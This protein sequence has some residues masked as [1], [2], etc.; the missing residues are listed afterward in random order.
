[1]FF[2]QSSLKFFGPIASLIAILFVVG[3][4]S[5]ATAQSNE[6]GS[7]KVNW[8]IYMQHASTA[9]AIAMAL[10]YVDHCSK[11]LD[12]EEQDYTDPDTGENLIIL[13]FTCAGNEDEGGSAFLRFN[14]SRKLFEKEPNL[15]PPMLKDF[16]FAG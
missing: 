12:I 10:S 14:G 8:S 11:E 4:L 15:G 16:T 9:S 6:S 13:S 1:M 7:A 2:A 3:A 5:Q